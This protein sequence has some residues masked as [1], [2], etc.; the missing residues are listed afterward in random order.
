MCPPTLE[1]RPVRTPADRKAFVELPW[2]IYRD[3]PNWVPPLLSMAYDAIDVEKN[4]FY[5]FGRLGMFNA[6]RGSE[7]A[8]RIAAIDNPLH[9]ETHQDHAGF[10]GFFEAENDAEVAGALFDAAATWLRARGKDTMR[11]PANPSVNA[12]YGLLVEGFDCP[13]VVMMTH[14]PPYYIDLVEGNGFTKAMGLYAWYVPTALYG[15]TRADK[16]PEKLVRVA[17]A[18]RRR[19]GYTIR[20]PDTKDWDNEVAKIKLV[21]RSAWEK[22]WGAVAMTDHEIEHL[23]KQLR[24]MADLDLIFVVEDKHGEVAGMSLSLPNLNQALL[25]AYPRPGVPEP[26]TLLKLL[27]YWKVRSVIDGVRAVALGV[28]EPH[29]GRGVDAL[30]MYETTRVALSKGYKWSEMSWILETND[31]MN[32]AIAMMG[33]EIYKTYRIYQKP[34]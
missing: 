14:N 16:V 1:I 9:N 27:W 6:W 23:A 4:P 3:D 31:M 29:R 8:G 13:P 12:E 34:L 30:L 18:V 11:G 7:L 19:Y 10:F 15:G 20:T 33:A 22:N 5:E 28:L 26:W 21:Y 2:K 24:Q 25:K 32:R 17:D